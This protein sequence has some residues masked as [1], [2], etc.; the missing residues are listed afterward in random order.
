MSI[1]LVSLL[2]MLSFLRRFFGTYE[3]IIELRDGTACVTRGKV[4]GRLPGEFSECARQFG[5]RRGMVYGERG[6]GVIRLTFSKE[7]PPAAHQQLRNIWNQ[8]Q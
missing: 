8:F 7:I 6:P 2:T 3:F 5:I 1:N 4:P